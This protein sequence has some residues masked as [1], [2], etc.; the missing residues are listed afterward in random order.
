[1]ILLMFMR[2]NSLRKLKPTSRGVDNIGLPRRFHHYCSY[3]ISAYSNS[4]LEYLNLNWLCTWPVAYGYS[5][6]CSRLSQYRPISVT[7]ILSGIAEKL[8]VRRILLPVVTRSYMLTISLVSFPL[9]VP[10]QH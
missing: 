6:T 8:F 10:F 2:L 3:E 9:V 5:H 7:P 4:H 1:M